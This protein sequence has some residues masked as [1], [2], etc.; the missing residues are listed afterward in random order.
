LAVMKDPKW[1]MREYEDFIQE[2]IDG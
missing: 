2:A 1:G